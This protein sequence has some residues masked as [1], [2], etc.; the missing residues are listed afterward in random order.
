MERKVEQL[1]MQG[2]SILATLEKPFMKDWNLIFSTLKNRNYS[3]VSEL[4]ILLRFGFQQLSKKPPENADSFIF[5]LMA[6]WRKNFSIHSQDV[7]AFFL[8]TL[9]ENL[10]H[11]CLADRPDATFLQHQAIQSFFSRTLDQVLLDQDT[12]DHIEKWAR[13]IIATNIL[14]MK[15]LAVVKEDRSDIRVEKVVCSNDYPVPQPLIDMC[16]GLK[17]VEMNVLTV[18]VSRLLDPLAGDSN[19]IQIPCLNDT[20]LICVQDTATEVSSQQRE[21]VS[22]MYLRQRKLHQLEAKMEWKDAALLFL[23][24]LLGVQDAESAL[25]AITEGLTDYMPFKRCSL[26]LYSPDERKQKGQ[27]VNE[28]GFSLPI[29]KEYLD[30]L[31]HAQPLYFS[32]A[33]A[34][35]PETY[36]QE[37]RM[38]SLVILPLFFQ[39]KNQLL[40]LA[41]LDQG[42]ASE[43]GV[44]HQTLTGLIK[45]GQFAGETLYPYWREALHLFGKQKGLLSEREKEVLKLVAEG[46][47]INEAAKRLHLSSYTVRDYVSSI[48]QKLDAKNRTDAAVKALK[49]KLIS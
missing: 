3:L 15:W 27:Y 34:A 14:P 11:K 32:N 41:L 12:E 4:N 7:E 24:R 46:L 8:V 35:L 22:R 33:S 48:I 20:L 26:Y 9:I 18:A 23:Q 40:G 44:S 16:T 21:F 42:E 45:F 37:H 30:A 38:K 36:L 29:S 28:D 19:V 49:M 43:F 31:T 6:E 5:S 39:S 25:E 2:I 47:S 17:A 1:V 13:M 10:F